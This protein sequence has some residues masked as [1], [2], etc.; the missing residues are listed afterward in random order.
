MADKN[1]NKQFINLL[2]DNWK[3]TRV[4][5]FDWIDSLSV[6]FLNKK[7]PR[8]GLNTFAKQICEI[9]DV[10]NAYTRALIKGKLD[11]TKTTDGNDIKERI[12]K[13]KLRARLRDA[14]NLLLT[15]IK[16]IDNWNRLIPI[17]GKTVPKYSILEL[18]TRHETL[19][20]G[21][22]IAYGCLLKI[23]FPKSWVYTWAIPQNNVKK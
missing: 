3:Y 14:D 1:D 19:H 4:L 13:Q 15:A 22:F 5:T 18:I 7:L 10:E 21:Q 11:F 8:P 16:N 6:D 17:F 23:K 20:H 2:I 9:A 12:N